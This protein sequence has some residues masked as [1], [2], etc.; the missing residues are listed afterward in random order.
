MKDWGP[1]GEAGMGSC[2]TLK[3]QALPKFQTLG[4]RDFLMLYFI[5]LNSH[6]K[7]AKEIILFSF[8]CEETKSP[9]QVEVCSHTPCMAETWFKSRY[10]EAVFFLHPTTHGIIHS[11]LG[12]TVLASS[13]ALTLS[14]WHQA[15]RLTS[16][17]LFPQPSTQIR[18]LSLCSMQGCS[19]DPK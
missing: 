18:M 8:I 11:R 10:F 17:G 13:S 1:H 16:Q 15:S 2:Q 7:L 5:S 4:E 6:Q 12:S 3:F 14:V 19:D 9:T